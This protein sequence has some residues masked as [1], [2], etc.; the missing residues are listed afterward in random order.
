MKFGAYTTKLEPVK[1]DLRPIYAFSVFSVLGPAGPSYGALKE[2]GAEACEPESLATTPQDS[3]RPA[4]AGRPGP[5]PT[6]QNSRAG[7][8][9]N[10]KNGKCINR[11]QI[12]VQ[13]LKIGR[14][15]ANFQCVFFCSNTCLSMCV[16][17][18]MKNKLNIYSKYIWIGSNVIF[19][20]IC[21]I[22]FDLVSFFKIY[23]QNKW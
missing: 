17:N 4:P 14:L 6:G 9:Q 5:Q 11:A 3:Q 7:R 8:P 1:S 2:S 15:G 20:N 13:G 10:G 19:L 12:G 16:M 23:F 21:C 18:N 22:F